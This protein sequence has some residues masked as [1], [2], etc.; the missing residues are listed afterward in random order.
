M[1]YNMCNVNKGVFKAVTFH[2]LVARIDI[3]K[4]PTA[5]SLRV[6]E[7]LTLYPEDACSRFLRIVGC[8]STELLSFAFQ[9]RVIFTVTVLLT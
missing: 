4:E 9:K 8:S 1:N 5:S 7:G 2:S 6:E 3:V